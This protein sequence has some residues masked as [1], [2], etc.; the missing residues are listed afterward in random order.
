M[1]PDTRSRRWAHPL[2]IWTTSVRACF[3]I[4]GPTYMDRMGPFQTAEWVDLLKMPLGLN[5]N[6]SFRFGL[7]RLNLEMAVFLCRVERIA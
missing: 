6:E 5:M 4:R 3:D 7:Y 2:L 1:Q